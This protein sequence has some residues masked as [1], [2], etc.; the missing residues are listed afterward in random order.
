M[1]A[2]GELNGKPLA[3]CQ[4]HDQFVAAMTPAEVEVADRSA[5]QRRVNIL[6]ETTQAILAV[7]ITCAVVYCVVLGIEAK[8]IDS[9]FVMIV[10]MYFLRTNHTKTGGVGGTDSR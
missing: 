4:V 6:W 7:L 2:D 5:G 3:K 1:S 9:A 10:T 8:V